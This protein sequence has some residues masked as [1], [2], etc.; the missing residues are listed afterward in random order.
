MEEERFEMD[1]EGMQ[2]DVMDMGNEGATI[3]LEKDSRKTFEV[4]KHALVGR[5]ISEK[6]L[7][8]KTVRE[9]ILKSWGHPKGL[10]T[11]DL[12]MNTYMFNFSEAMTPRKIMEDA[13]WNILG[14]L[15]CLHRWVPKF[16]IH[17]VDY[18]FSPFWIQVHGVPL[19]GMSLANA[20]RIA[21]KVGEVEEVE[22]PLIGNKIV[23]G[24]LR[25]KV[26]VN[27]K[28]PLITG[29]WVP[30]KDMPKTWIWIH[31][32][33][34]Q[35]FCYNCGR[36][37]HCKKDCKLE[38]QMALWDPKKPRFGPGLGVAPLKP[39][40]DVIAGMTTRNE[41][42]GAWHA[43]ATEGRGGSLKEMVVGE[44]RRFGRADMTAA[45]GDSYE[46]THKVAASTSDGKSTKAPVHRPEAG[47]EEMTREVEH[48]IGGTRHGK[49]KQ[50]IASGPVGKEDGLEADEGPT[51]E[52]TRID[53]K[54]RRIRPGLGPMKIQDLDLERE[55][56]GLAQ[57]VIILDSLSPKRP[58]PKSPKEA[59]T[60][61]L[62]MN[63]GP[64]EISKCRRAIK[65][66]FGKQVS[67]DGLVS[68][69]QPTNMELV[70]WE[71]R[72]RL[73]TKKQQQYF[74]VFPEDAEEVSPGKGKDQTETR[75]TMGNETRDMLEGFCERLKLKR[76]REIDEGVDNIE[77]WAKRMLLIENSR[78]DA[79]EKRAEQIQIHK[80]KGAKSDDV[81]VAGFVLPQMGP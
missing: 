38:M 34:L 63:M 79:S 48:V 37:G 17:E 80:E 19:E 78:T 9:M 12:S 8:R 27:I 74:V 61:S 59:T 47:K 33:K 3:E 52:V 22:D 39:I 58:C 25:A 45:G 40:A 49:G 20:Q 31:Y 18:N 68:S 35:D 16:S 6:P 13:P 44:R 76:T 65:G 21:E 14:S 10:H 29:F 26:V 69:N 1:E 30:R 32:E 53:L 23:R 67:Y 73:K 77:P 42:E 7:N 54:E 70:I 75:T 43:P 24:F 15:L 66:V 2:E 50:K 51:E 28:K 60:S 72:D 55:D 5:I 41:G 11:I 62:D 46:M 81:G 57:P 36:L 56:I 4:A 64:E 71:P